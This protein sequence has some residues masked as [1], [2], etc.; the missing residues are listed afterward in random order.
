M[1]LWLSETMSCSIILI[2]NLL[3]LISF[4]GSTKDTACKESVYQFI[5]L[6]PYV[7]KFPVLLLS[8]LEKNPKKPNKEACQNSRSAA[9]NL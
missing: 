9:E 6:S 4:L 2:V 7:L 8:H 3:L 1:P 5:I